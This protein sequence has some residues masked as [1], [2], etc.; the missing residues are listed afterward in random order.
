[1]M[2]RHHA[3]AHSGARDVLVVAGYD[4]PLREVFLH[5]LLTPDGDLGAEEDVLYASVNEPWRDWTN[6]VTITGQLARLGI[7]VPDSLLKA[8]RL[9]QRNQAGNRVVEHHT[10]RPPTVLV[11]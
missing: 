9:D 8:V 2:S 6:V 1:M 4:R 3:Q 11:G 7:V 10:D 5:V